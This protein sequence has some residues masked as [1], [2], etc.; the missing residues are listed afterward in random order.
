MKKLINFF[1][2]LGIAFSTSG[3]SHAGDSSSTEF[4]LPVEI[5][6][7]TNLFQNADVYFLVK[8]INPV[9]GNE[10]FLFFDDN[11]QGQYVDITKDTKS[12]DFSFILSDYLTDENGIQL[13]IP[14]LV[15]GRIYLS[16]IRP[17]EL[18]IKDAEGTLRI[19]DADGFKPRDANYYTLYDKV[20]LTY[21]DGGSWVNPTAVDFFSL[22]IRI[23]QEGALSESTVAGLDRNR[24]QAFE[25]LRKIVSQEDKTTNQEWNKLFLSFTDSNSKTTTLRFMSPGKAM[26]K[27]VEGAIP[28]DE[29]YLNNAQ[30]Y[31]VNWTDFIWDYYKTHSL[32]IDT[33]ELRHINPLPGDEYL[34]KGFVDGETERWVFSTDAGFVVEIEKP[35]TSVP[36]FAGAIYPFDAANNTPKAIIIRQL[37]SAFEVGL[38][39]LADGVTLDRFYLTNHMNDYFKANQLL[40][41]AEQGP[42]YDLYSKALHSFGDEEPIYSFAYDDALGQ[43]GTL[44]DP[45]A[46]NLSK[47][48]ITLGDMTGT[49]IADPYLDDIV[50]DVT[51]LIGEGSE[52]IHKGRVLHYGDVLGGVTTPFEVTLNGEKA[53]IYFKPVMVHPNFPS[54]DGI[55]V[56]KD[57]QITDNITITFPSNPSK[58]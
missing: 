46:S 2:F 3:F 29:K 47:V 26:A 18:E 55:L 28:F 13:R 49:E 17:M 12:K 34:F 10:C 50:Y 14:Q 58:K 54:A 33:S 23:E 31:G 39:P 6:N 48:K 57:P 19:V 4:F 9:T 22:P 32:L 16:L 7:N 42:W 44:H 38:L 27:H 36:F 56:Q 45:N 41:E 40:S 43:D 51:V 11:G 53:E 37:T 1:L 5:L 52:V 30:L 21:V 8:G 35:E 15:S 20:E 25:Q 24:E